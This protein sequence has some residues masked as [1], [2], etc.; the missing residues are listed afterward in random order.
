MYDARGDDM[1][2]VQHVPVIFEGHFKGPVYHP[3]FRLA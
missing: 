1:C 2:Q 3:K